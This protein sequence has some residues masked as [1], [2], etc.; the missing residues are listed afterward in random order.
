MMEDNIRKGM[1]IYAHIYIHTYINTHTH[2]H[3]YM[4]WSVCCTAEIGTTL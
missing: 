2:T 4:T 3:T 1:Y